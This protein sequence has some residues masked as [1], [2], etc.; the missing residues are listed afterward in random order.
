GE[1]EDDSLVLWKEVDP[2]GD[3]CPERGRNRE[4]RKL[5][6]RPPPAFVSQYVAIY[7]RAEQLFDEEWVSCRGTGDV[8]AY[9]LREGGLAEE[10][11]DQTLGLVLGERFERRGARPRQPASPGR[12]DVQELRTR[13]ADD[14]NPVARALGDVLDEIEQGRLGPL[15]VVEN[16]EH[17]LL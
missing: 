6:R 1:L 17:R 11:V 16:D 14:Q 13:E 12:A 7:E 8:L 10:V 9:R 3:Q 2:R 4:H 15:E 5:G